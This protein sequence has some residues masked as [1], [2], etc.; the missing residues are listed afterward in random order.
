[1]SNDN[2]ATARAFFEKA[3]GTADM[4]MFDACCSPDIVVRTG[5]SPAGPIVGLAAYKGA[6]SGFAQA[7]P[8][9][10]FVVHELWP[11]PDGDKVIARFTASAV[12][13]NDYF[14]VPATRQ[15]VAMEEVHILSFAGGKIVGN[16]VSGTNFPFEYLMFPVLKDAVLG[17]LPLATAE[18]ITRV[19]GSAL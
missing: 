4:A 12:F 9:V 2:V 8:V 10:D 5:L 11:S 15:V 16:I 14:G 18:Q 13:L 6:F 19:G 17:P 7:F 3:I 1:M